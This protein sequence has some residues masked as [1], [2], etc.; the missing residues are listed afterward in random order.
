MSSVSFSIDIDLARSLTEMFQLTTFV[1]TG[2]FEGDTVRAVRGLFPE[3]HTIELSETLFA[4]AAEAFRHTEGVHVWQGGS[5]SRLRELRE[6]LKSRRVLYWLDAH[7]CVA[8]ETAGQE[9]ECPLL[10]EL[11][12]I[13]P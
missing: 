10:D 12:A 8:E 3:I 11:E 4:G 5:A 6:K 7:W 9:S 1:E 13:D 2:T